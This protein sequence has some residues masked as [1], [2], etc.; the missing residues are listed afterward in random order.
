MNKRIKIFSRLIFLSIIIT[1]LV[2]LAGSI[3]RATGSG[4]GC[5]DWPKCFGQYIPP[6]DISQLPE[7]YKEVFKVQ[8]KEIADF[9]A[10]HTWVEYI[11]RLLGVVMGFLV[12]GVLIF[13]FLVRK[14]FSKMYIFSIV[15]F[16]ATLFQAWLGAK[17]VSSN[18]APVKI[19]VHMVFALIIL[20]ALIY[21]YHSVNSTTHKEKLKTNTLKK[22]TFLL[23]FLCI[24]QILLGTQVRQQIDEI[25]LQFGNSFRDKW[26][27]NLNWIFDVHK[28]L[29]AI[30][31][32]LC[33]Y[34]Y[35]ESKKIKENITKYSIL[36]NLLLIAV[37]AEF[38]VG[39]ILNY[40]AIPAFFQ[41]V[42]LIFSSIIFG[43][44]L[45]IYLNNQIQFL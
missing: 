4:M 41:P 14:E 17:V 12:L 8:G 28:T 9:N 35:Y 26:I 24:V 30:L 1:Y 6:T 15:V 38:F 33:F 25:A 7:N 10:L 32:G 18:L 16:L 11:N 45:K 37:G 34:V 39:L 31:I 2:I 3:V 19:T 13:S 5:P 23:L 44:S 22:A 40:A 29:A 43:I 20:A 42:H 21:Q 36:P 27:L